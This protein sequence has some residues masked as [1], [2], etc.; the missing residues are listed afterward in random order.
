[1]GNLVNECTDWYPGSVFWVYSPEKKRMGMITPETVKWRDTLSNIWEKLHGSCCQQLQPFCFTL[2]NRRREGNIFSSES[3]FHSGWDTE[4]L[5]SKKA[6]DKPRL[7]PVKVDAV[8]WNK[9]RTG[10]M[11]SFLWFL[12]LSHDKM[13]DRCIY[14]FSFFFI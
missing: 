12:S 1:M 10:G 14:Y 3:T 2:T 4:Y 5:L 8:I 11:S 9:K 7:L 13:E 6:H